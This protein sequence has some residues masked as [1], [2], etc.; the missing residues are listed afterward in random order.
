MLA[1]KT[2][3]SVTLATTFASGAFVGYAA[4]GQ[5]HGLPPA[6]ASAI[7]AP[8]LEELE[9]RGYDPTEMVEARQ[10]YDEYLK[11]CNYWWDEFLAAHQANIDVLNAK[12][13]RHL[14]ALDAKFRGR[15]G[16]K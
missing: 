8:Q 5:V 16:A 10:A 7:Y 6:D 15:T 4:K 9:L 11:G 14:A 3:L 12:F 13:D 2:L 1:D